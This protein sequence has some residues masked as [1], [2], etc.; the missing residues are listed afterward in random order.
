MGNLPNHYESE[1]DSETDSEVEQVSNKPDEKEEKDLHL[2]KELIMKNFLNNINTNTYHD[3]DDL[4]EIMKKFYALNIPEYEPVI[5]IHIPIQ[6]DNKDYLDAFANQYMQL[7]TKGKS[8][9][10]LQFRD[11]MLHFAV[12]NEEMYSFDVLNNLKFIEKLVLDFSIEYSDVSSNVFNRII[13]FKLPNLKELVFNINDSFDNERT[14][15]ESLQAPYI[16]SIILPPKLVKVDLRRTYVFDTP[17]YDETFIRQRKSFIQYPENIEEVYINYIMTLRI[18]PFQVDPSY[19]HTYPMFGS[20]Y[21]TDQYYMYP[22]EDTSELFNLLNKQ[23]LKKLYYYAIFRTEDIMSNKESRKQLCDSINRIDDFFLV[24]TMRR[25]IDGYKNQS[26]EQKQSEY[27]E[28]Q[29]ET[30]LI[31]IQKWIPRISTIH[32]IRLRQD[33]TLSIWVSS[34][35]K[36]NFY[37]LSEK[38]A[39]I[40]LGESTKQ[41]LTQKGD[42]IFDLKI[43]RAHV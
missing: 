29:V 6:I 38:N 39:F 22:I 20:Y 3:L 25:N 15:P 9:D 41:F 5:P 36:S 34:Q 14:V 8:T 19:E 24:L 33:N 11:L 16:D 12:N 27:V 35:V 40:Q 21:Y 17:T 4:S 13:D 42:I 26:G 28:R 7:Q 32:R 43:G 23:N 30:S 18:D 37:K 10:H 31:E 1:S 2:T